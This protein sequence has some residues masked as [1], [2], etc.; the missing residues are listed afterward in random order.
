MCPD[1]GQLFPSQTGS[2]SDTPKGCSGEDRGPMYFPHK[3]VCAHVTSLYSRH[4][5]H[6][7]WV[8]IVRPYLP[9]I[10][11]GVIF[12]MDGTPCGMVKGVWKP[13]V[14]DSNHCS[15]AR[16]VWLCTCH[17]TSLGLLFREVKGW[18]G[19]C[20]DALTVP[21]FYD[22]WTL[23]MNHSHSLLK[24]LF[25][26]TLDS[27]GLTFLGDLWF[28]CGKQAEQVPLQGG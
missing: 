11:T 26:M 10:I 7:S 9:G 28:P 5:Y 19:W 1:T 18:T 3:T 13:G 14:S 22:P 21:Q 2:A 12:L 4:N 27:E 16:V 6:L 23:Q 25:P 20:L 17:W 8:L 24:S 15:A